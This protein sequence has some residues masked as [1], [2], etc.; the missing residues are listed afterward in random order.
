VTGFEE[1]FPTYPGMPLEEDD[2]LQAWCDECEK[3]R[4][5]DDSWNDDTMKFARIKITCEAC[6]FEI[7]EFSASQQ[8]RN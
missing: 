5:K 2:D 7:K 1:S 4:V 8:S 6:F 3:V